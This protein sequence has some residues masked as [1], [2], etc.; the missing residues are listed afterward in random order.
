MAARWFLVLLLLLHPVRGVL[1][2]GPQARTLP[3]APVETC[4]SD[5]CC[6]LCAELDACPCATDPGQDRD[7]AP[8]APPTTGEGPRVIVTGGWAVWAFTLPAALPVRI[9]GA[10]APPAVFTTVNEF[11]SVVCVW[12]T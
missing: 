7:P 6:P 9:A 3:A 5:G 12:T 1:A 10:R 11:L 2:A 8:V 4:S